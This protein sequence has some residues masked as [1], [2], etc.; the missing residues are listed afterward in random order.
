MKGL[1]NTESQGLIVW[2]CEQSAVHEDWLGSADGNAVCVT[3]PG[4]VCGCALK[5]SP[6]EEQK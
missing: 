3:D 1:E 6:K 2:A 4:P 5:C